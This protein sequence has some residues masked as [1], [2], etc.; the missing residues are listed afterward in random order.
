MRRRHAAQASPLCRRGEGREGAASR[1]AWAM[2]PRA[3]RINWTAERGS[4]HFCS[5]DRTHQALD[6]QEADASTARGVGAGNASASVGGGEADAVDAS[7]Q[8]WA[9]RTLH[10]QKKTPRALVPS[11]VC[12]PPGPAATGARAQRSRLVAILV[13]GTG[14]PEADSAM[15]RRRREWLASRPRA[16]EPNLG[17]SPRGALPR[18]G[19][20]RPPAMRCDKSGAQNRPGSCAALVPRDGRRQGPSPSDS[21]PVVRFSTIGSAGVRNPRLRALRSAR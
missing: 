14:V 4:A 5:T 15:A 16:V 3:W 11:F 18:A 1:A 2:I 12:W 9:T 21:G 8:R 13:A 6:Q 17:W 20:E 19:A 7:W 10:W